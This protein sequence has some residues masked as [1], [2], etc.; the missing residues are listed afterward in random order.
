[1]SR[2]SSANSLF[3][4][5][6]LFGC[7][8]PLL[9]P[10][11]K[12]LAAKSGFRSAFLKASAM[13]A[14]S[15]PENGPPSAAEPPC[16]IDEAASGDAMED[17]RWR[18]EPAAPAPAKAAPPI[19]DRGVCASAI[20]GDAEPI[21]LRLEVSFL[22]RRRRMTKK[23]RMPPATRAKNPRMAIT[24]IAQWGKGAALPAD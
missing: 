24:A 1:M 13:I 15:A 18:T 10:S 14:A 7:E 6:P 11:S 19:G 20:I 9:S 21:E 2:P 16:D 22:L 12:G 4:S 23:A 5:P 8:P 17:A 3:I